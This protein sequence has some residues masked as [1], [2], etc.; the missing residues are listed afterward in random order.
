MRSKFCIKHRL[1]FGC[2]SL[3][4]S[5]TFAIGA[6]AQS[7]GSDTYTNAC[8]SPTI[9]PVCDPANGC[10]ITVFLK[11]HGKAAED[12]PAACVD[13]ADYPTITW[14]AFDTGGT[15]EIKFDQKNPTGGGGSYT[16]SGTN[17]VSVTFNHATGGCYHYH[18]KYC[19]SDG[20][21]GE[22]DPKV[23]VNGHGGPGPR[24]K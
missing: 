3:V 4:A 6:G 12:Q 19:K 5:A 17:S 20:N 11:S 22:I 18:V 9:L 24:R 14:N 23:V 13:T 10:A 2:L 1:L 21:C 15:I 7:C 16:V 8:T